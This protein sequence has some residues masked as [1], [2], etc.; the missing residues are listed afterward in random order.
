MKADAQ[1]GPSFC[2]CHGTPNNAK[3]PK[4][5]EPFDPGEFVLATS[6][7]IPVII[8][9]PHGGLKELPCPVRK[10]GVKCNDGRTRTVGLT[11]QQ[12]MEE[13]GAKPYLV[14]LECRRLWVDANRGTKDCF[15][16]P[17]ETS[18]IYDHE[19]GE[20]VHALYHGKM[21]EYICEVKKKFGHPP[22]ILDVH[23]N[24]EKKLWGYMTRGTTSGLAV[25]RLIDAYG[26]EV[27]TGP[28]SIFGEMTKQGYPQHP[29]EGLEET[30]FN[31]G[32]I[33]RRYSKAFGTHS[34]QVEISMIFRETQELAISTGQAIA[35]ALLRFLKSYSLDLGSATPTPSEI[36][37]E[38]VKN[39]ATK[40]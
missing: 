27:V 36:P 29:E 9:I 18:V 21:E 35:T 26:E 14:C 39:S 16:N 32:Y 4:P 10:C 19:Y 8:S 13:R 5:S 6:G 38:A 15:K 24:S 23:G 22:L 11:I 34:F 28:R 7:D 12:T 31:G 17:D 1:D 30:A 25:G 2:E 37:A 40:N 20:Q 3:R 33:T